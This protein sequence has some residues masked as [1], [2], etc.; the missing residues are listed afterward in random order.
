M[1]ARSNVQR[2][3]ECKPQT[4][5]KAKHMGGPSGC[6]VHDLKLGHR[7]AL[8]ERVGSAARACHSPHGR[9]GKSKSGRPPAPSVVNRSRHGRAPC[10]AP[11]RG[12][13]STG[14]RA[15][16]PNDGD[17]HVFDLYPHEQEEDLAVHH[18]AQMVPGL[19]VLE[20]DVQAIFDAHLPDAQARVL[21]ARSLPGGFPVRFHAPPF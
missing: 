9:S 2:A 14:G 1:S 6:T 3:I 19:V 7:L 18:V 17:L 4:Q 10:H 21:C 20:L 12:R 8:V 16:A 13:K 5:S 11:Q 15:L